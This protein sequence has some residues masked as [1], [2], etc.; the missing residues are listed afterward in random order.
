MSH[1]ANVKFTFRTIGGNK[2]SMFQKIQT[3]EREEESVLLKLRSQFS[4]T[5]FE[6]RQLSWS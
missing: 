1:T 2:L 5:N 3:E 6:I 4:G